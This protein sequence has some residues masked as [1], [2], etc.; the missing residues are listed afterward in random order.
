MSAS[1][2]AAFLRRAADQYGRYWRKAA[3]EPGAESELARE[4]LGRLCAL[5]LVAMSEG[6]VLARPALARFAI[7]EPSVRPASQ[8]VLALE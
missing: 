7:G 4:A 5:R 8:P 1:E 2:V 6:G 3:R